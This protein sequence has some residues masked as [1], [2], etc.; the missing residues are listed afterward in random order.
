MKL[1]WLCN[2]APGV[3]KEKIGGK[4]IGGLWMDH[5][6]SGLMARED[7]TMHILC[8]GKDWARGVLCDRLTY[9]TFPGGVPHVARTDLNPVFAGQ[10]REFGPDVIHVWGTEFP[11]SL[12]MAEAA[13]ME[14]MEEKLLV[15][16]QGL[17]SFIAEHYAEGIP[18]R[19]C[20]RYTFRDLIRRD[21]IL[22]QIQKFR[23]RGENEVKALQIANH[24]VGRTAWDEAATAMIRPDRQYHFCSE[25]LRQ[26]FYQ[27][28]WSYAACKPHRI[29][30]S[31]CYY[32]V[33]GFHYVLEAFAQV[34]K[35][36]PDAI[37]AVPGHSFLA[38]DLKSRLRRNSYQAYL[39]DLVKKHGLEGKIEFLGSMDADQMK[40]A[41]LNAN[42]FV[43]SST[44]ENSPNTLGE[45][46]V[47]GMPCVASDVGGVSSLIDHDREG[48][49]Y[50]S[51][52]PYMLSYYIQKVFA[53]KDRAEAMG[54]AARDHGLKT[55][56][57]AENLARLL[58]IYGS[59]SRDRKE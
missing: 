45:A 6:L 16:I 59:L 41:Y 15:N 53:M 13:R 40:Q 23:L 57:P 21:N 3:L 54:S 9:A 42:V 11:H 36:Y 5:V 58:E 26:E 2:M 56:D 1:L 14:G 33:K 47:L 18:Y 19:V 34:L 25:T 30:A 35:Q 44:I 10:L 52:A 50:Q 51:T 37:L 43:L 55:H 31:G 22:D 46:M 48:F 32:S 7:I 24:V 38:S 8:P 29:L 27:D 4:A 28:R 20:R 39:A 12:A 49:V 17:C